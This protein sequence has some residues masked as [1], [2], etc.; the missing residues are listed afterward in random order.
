MTEPFHRDRRD[1]FLELGA[2]LTIIAGV[3]SIVNGVEGLLARNHLFSFLP[4]ATE[5]LVTFCGILLV[6]FGVVAI[7]G[8]VYALRPRAHLTPV[9]LGAGLGMLG[10]GAYGFILGLAAVLLFWLANV[11]L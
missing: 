4:S 7:A 11:D 3:L 10:G 9:L 1:I 8:G 2:I 6:M 5:S